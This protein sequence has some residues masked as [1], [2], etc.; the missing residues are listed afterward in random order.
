MTELTLLT[1]SAAADTL[2]QALGGDPAKVEG[3]ADLIRGEVSARGACPRAATLRRV[4]QFA[5]RAAKLDEALVEEVCDCLER[6]G[7]IVLAAGGILYATPLRAV[8]RGDMTLRIASS[9]PTRW[10]RERVTGRWAVSGIVRTCRVEDLDHTRRAIAAARGVVITPADWAGLDRVPCADAQWLESLDRRLRSEP[11]APGGLERDEV[12]AWS[13]C[14]VTSS[15]LRW[16]TRGPPDTAARLWRARNRW[17]RWH[18]AWTQQGGT[19]SDAPFVCLRPDEGTRAKYAL[20]RNLGMPVKGTVVTQDER[21]TLSVSYWLP[22][23]EYRYLAVV[24]SDSVTTR[25]GSHWTVPADRLSGLIK[26]LEMRL[27]ILFEE[28][29]VR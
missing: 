12:L 22:V 5:A 25:D 3:I 13:G 18:Y 27:G 23:A 7:D 28:E 16:K 1:D 29:S 11:E 17:G 8:D 10:L 26:T 6:E 2:R 15:G 24:S 9:L 4:R 14:E 19:P 20:A 21:A